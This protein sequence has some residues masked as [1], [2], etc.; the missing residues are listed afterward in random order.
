MAAEE[1]RVG[2][3]VPCDMLRRHAVPATMLDG[4]ARLVAH[5]FEA[6]FDFGALVL[7]EGSLAPAEDEFH[8]ALP[9]AYA[10]DLEDFSVRQFLDEA[11]ARLAFETQRAGTPRCEMEQP[12]GL[13]PA[14]DVLREDVEGV[15][16]IGRHTHGN[17][18]SR[19]RHAH[20]LRFDFSIWA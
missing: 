1:E 3:V 5:R 2:K 13:P 4:H 19:A 11:P 20:A 10:S 15:N 16:G 8:P 9:F 18:N 12:I 6:H 7:D 14:G 17:E